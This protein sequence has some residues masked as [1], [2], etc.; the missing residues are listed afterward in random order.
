MVVYELTMDSMGVC[1]CMC[2]CVCVWQAGDN[3]C[4]SSGAI[5]L[6]LLS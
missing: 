5:A 1:V 3:K 6:V 4:H 2:V